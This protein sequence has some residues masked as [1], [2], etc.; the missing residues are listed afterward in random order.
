[1]LAED[2]YGNDYP[3]D[4]VDSDDEFGKGA[5]NYRRGGSDDEDY[6]GEDPAWSDD[7]ADLQHPWKRGLSKIEASPGGTTDDRDHDMS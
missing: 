4:E 5:Y 3:E 1:M 7:D 6:D 2:Y